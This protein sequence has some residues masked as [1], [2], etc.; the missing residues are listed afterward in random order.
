MQHPVQQSPERFQS[1]QTVTEARIRVSLLGVTGWQPAASLVGQGEEQANDRPEVA[2][3]SN[4]VSPFLWSRTQRTSKLKCS[5]EL[6]QNP[7]QALGSRRPPR[8]VFPKEI[9]QGLKVLLTSRL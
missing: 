6:L 2:A 1:R 5:L 9:N 7:R 8:A 4:L 3:G